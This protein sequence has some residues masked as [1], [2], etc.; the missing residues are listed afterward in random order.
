M[1]INKLSPPK[2]LPLLLLGFLCLSVLILG[3]IACRGSVSPQTTQPVESE[4]DSIHPSEDSKD[5]A[6]KGTEPTGSDP[7]DAIIDTGDPSIPSESDVTIPVETENISVTESPETSGG[8]IVTLAPPEAPTEPDLDQEGLDIPKEELPRIDINTNGG[9]EIQSKDYYLDATISVSGCEEA[10]ALKDVTA[11]VRVRGNST[12]GAPKKPYR[13]K[14]ETKQ[15]MLGLNDGEKFKSWCLMADYFDSSML[16]T[17]ATFAFA[18][19]LLGGKYYSSDCTPVEVYVNGDYRG[20]YL[21]CEQTQIDNDRIDIY[22]AEDGDPSLEI[23]YLMIGQGGR[24]DEPESIVVYP[25]ITVRDRNGAEMYFDGMNFALSGSGYTQAQ[26]DYVVKYVSAVFKVVASALYEDRYYRLDRQG[27][28]TLRP[29][30][31][32]K[33]MTKQEKQI[34]TIDAVFN[35]ESAVRMCILDEIAKNLDAMTFNMY[36]DLSPY[37]DGRLTLA[38]PWDFDFA[39]ANTHYSTTHSTSGFYATNLSYS[40]GM[41]TNLWYV[42]LGSIDWFEAMCKDV[43]QDY[44]PKLQNV[45]MEVLDRTYRYSN[46]YDRDWAKWGAGAHRSLIHHHCPEDLYSFEKHADAGKFLNNWLIGRLK[47]LNRQWG[48]GI[49]EVAP[50]APALQVDFTQDTSMSYI[51][52][53][54]RAECSITAKGLRLSL[55]EPYDPYFYVDFTT[56]PDTY[57]ADDYY[58]LEIEYMIPKTNTLDSYS[59]E[60]F[61]CSGNTWDAVGGIST[62]TD[63]G[64]ADGQYHTIRINLMDTGFWDGGIH[65]IRIDFFNA[66]EAGDIMFIKSVKLLP[67]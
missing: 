4:S 37:G 36:V 63:L 20:V 5:I 24:N 25:E 39:M 64:Q 34:S 22:E 26:K 13:I 11:G 23:G 57:L 51:T 38:A 33:G 8:Q 46:A 48:N 18:E 7:T 30:S 49:V 60:F 15:S 41:R 19:V 27:N 61:L 50:E 31:E 29:A 53:M 67:N 12:A 3:L 6:T 66:C 42:M 1:R 32:L 17:W 14:F 47:W 59:A 40:E 45:A 52:G 54:K 44:Y 65:R 9:R 58:I 35:I 21:L 43:W 2:R 10:Y 56:L 62:I 28:M 16:R 55:L